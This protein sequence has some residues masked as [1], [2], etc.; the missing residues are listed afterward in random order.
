MDIVF[1]ARRAW[2][3][4]K[5]DDRS[6]SNVVSNLVSLNTDL[7]KVKEQLYPFLG[8]MGTDC[9][10]RLC[11]CF[12]WHHSDIVVVGDNPLRETRHFEAQVF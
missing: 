6:R 9:L 12:N 8:T 2:V 3:W 11:F 7:R 10:A 4:G 1:S 5:K